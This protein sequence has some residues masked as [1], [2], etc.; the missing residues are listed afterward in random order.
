MEKLIVFDGN[1]I[2]NRAFYGVRPLSTKEGIPTNAIF[3]F[4]NIIRRAMQ[5]AG[6]N[7]KYAAIAFDRKEPTF[8]HKACDFYKANRKGMPEELAMQL[9]YAKEVAAALGLT[10]VEMPGFEADDITGTLTDSFSRRGTE[11]II[12]TGDRDSFQLV[13][14]R[15]TVHLAATNETRI[16]GVKE[17]FEQYGV[18]PKRLI[19]IKAIMGDTSDNIPG[20]AGIG[21]KGAIKLIAQ[22]GDVEGVYANIQDIKGALHDKLL[23]GK[24]MAYTSRFLAEIRLDAP[25]ETAPEGYIY[26]GQ[27]VPALRELYTKLEFRKLLEQ[28][29]GEEEVPQDAELPEQ[30]TY[31]EAESISTS[32]FGVLPAEDGCLVFDG[33]AGYRISW[34]KAEVLFATGKTALVWSVKETLHTL[35]SKG[36]SPAC[37][38]EDLSLLAYLSSPADN[39]ISFAGAVFRATQAVVEDVPDPALYFLLYDAFR[40]SLTEALEK[41][42]TEVEKPLA[43]V[44]ADMEKEGFLL[45]RRGLEAFTAALEEEI[46][47]YAEQIYAL[48]GH[49]FNINSPKQLGEVLFEERKLPHYKKTKSGYSTDAETLEK[50]ALYDPLVQLILDYRKAAKLKSTYGEGLLKV[51]SEDGRVHTTFKQTMTMTG[52]LSSAEPNLQNIPVRTEK[53]R[54]LR[55]FFK[56]REGHVLVD[57]DYSQIE[58]RLLAHI[59]G[60]E[61]LCNAFRQGADIHTATAAQVYGVPM[62]MV[63]GEMRKSAKAV[64]FG[65]IYGIGEYSLSQDI[66]VSVKEAKGFIARY[67]E[68]YPAIRDYMEWAKSFAAEHGYVETLYGRRREIPEMKQANKMRRAFG[69]RVAMNTPIQGTAADLIKI[70]MIRVFDALKKA[71]LEAKLILQIHDELIVEAPEGEAQQV[72]A[73]LE[74]EMVEAAEFAVPLVADAKIGK[75]WYDAKD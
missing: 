63:T 74:K 2:L 60:D 20:V 6:E 73:L 15:V 50:L 24:E 13:N 29:P 31:T 38:M 9:P 61:A 48:A 32:R 68:K 3:G 40:P 16:T 71:G 35:W 27:N 11:C 51:I 45:D 5:E 7:L 34:D 42:Y 28:L 1:S 54:E 58:L 70:A 62:E 65:I 17:I 37:E 12:V 52:R 67:F 4:V 69:E 41:L 46:D 14:N 55:K 53:G 25:I 10:V 47:L 19:E 64:N 8:R 75:S 18:D 36:I 21:E 30:V 59:S 56:A 39:G 33:K 72:K 43:Y 22:Y 26:E 66:G 49:S 57:A 44:L 23:A